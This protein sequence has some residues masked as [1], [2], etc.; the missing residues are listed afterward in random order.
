MGNAGAKLAVTI[1]RNDQASQTEGSVVLNG[2]ALPPSY[3]PTCGGPSQGA[4][5]RHM[6][7]SIKD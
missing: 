2:L 3:L 5:N 1:V 7:Q 4:A 6:F